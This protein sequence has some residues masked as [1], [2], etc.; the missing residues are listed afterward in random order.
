MTW[1]YL[2]GFLIGEVGVGLEPGDFVRAEERPPEGDDRIGDLP[3]QEGLRAVLRARLTTNFRIQRLWLYNRLTVEARTRT[4]EEFDPFRDATFQ[5]ELSVEE[6]FAPMFRLARWDRFSQL[7][8]YAEITVSG[9]VRFGLLDL[10]P[11]AGIIV[12]ELFDGVTVN[13]D[14]YYSLRD[15]ERVGGPGVLLFVWAYF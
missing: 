10:R 7:W 12:E 6:A 9:E 4:F 1:T 15:S 11:S 13:L 8:L 2:D 3:R 14:L 5:H